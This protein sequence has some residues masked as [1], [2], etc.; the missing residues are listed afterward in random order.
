MACLRPPVI[1]GKAAVAKENVSSVTHAPAGSPT[2]GMRMKVVSYKMCLPV[3]PMF[4]T[5]TA[6]FALANHRNANEGYVT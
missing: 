5:L 6:T 2:I 1:Y 4:S 3:I